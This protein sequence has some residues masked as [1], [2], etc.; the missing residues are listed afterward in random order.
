MADKGSQVVVTGM[1]VVTEDEDFNVIGV[2]IHGDDR[3]RYN[4]VLNRNGMSL[5]AEMGEMRAEVT[6]IVTEK[7]NGNWLTV[8][9]YEE[10]EEEEEGEDWM[11]SDE[12]DD[13]D[14]EDDEDDW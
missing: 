9:H 6:G 8:Q 14:Y 5:A 1:V 11:D 2:E 10:P 13:D 4:V 7:P 12:W 3:L